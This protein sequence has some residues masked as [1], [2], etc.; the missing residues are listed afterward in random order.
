[1]GPFPKMMPG[2][3]LEIC[4]RIKALDRR[5]VALDLV[6]HVGV[7]RCAMGQQEPRDRGAA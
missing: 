7:E 5:M 2:E 1:M 3:D 4:N 6:E